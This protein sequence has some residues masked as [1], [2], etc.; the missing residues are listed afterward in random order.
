MHKLAFTCLLLLLLLPLAAQTIS[1]GDIR[2][3]DP[4]LSADGRQL[5]FSRPDYVRNQGTSSNLSD[6]WVRTVNENG[7]WGR[8]LN[9]GSPIN[10]FGAD[11]PVGLSADGNRLAVLREGVL[12]SIDVLERRGRIWSIH[13]SLP[14]PDALRGVTDLSFNPVTFRLVYASGGAESDLYYLQATP[15]G[16]WEGPLPMNLLNTDLAESRPTFSA[17]NR[18]L[19]YRSGGDW[20]RQ[21]DRGGRARRLT[22]TPWGAEQISTAPAGPVTAVVTEGRGLRAAALVS[23]DLPP[24]A[25]LTRGFVDR[26]LPPGERFTLLPVAADRTLRVLPDEQ[27]RYAVF[28][29]EGESL[30][31][32]APDRAG[33]SSG[34]GG[35]LASAAGAAPAAD[36]VAIEDD[37]ARRVAEIRRLDSLR[38]AT[39]SDYLGQ[40]DPELA[41]LTARVRAAN[42]YPTDTVPPQNATRAR[43]ADDISEL[44]RMKAKFR[45][46]QEEKLSGRRNRTERTDDIR[47]ST[48]ERGVTRLSV[49]RDTARTDDPRLRAGRIQSE[50]NNG[51]YN[52]RTAARGGSWERDLQ[53][54]LPNQERISDQDRARL[55]AEYERQMAELEE[56]RRRLRQARN[57]PDPQP[58]SAPAPARQ[59]EARSPTPSEYTAP[60][61]PPT[62]TYTPP[63][64][65][66]TAQLAGITF[67]PNTAYP[68]GPGYGAL[69]QLA[70]QVQN[71]G[72]VVEIRVH[73]SVNLDRRTAQLLSEE[74][75]VT[76]RN[77]LL[78]QGINAANFRV[79]G[80][81]NNLTGNGGERVELITT[82]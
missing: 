43:Y 79:V 15:R 77:Y 6:V 63:P 72:V 34:T 75:A 10:S 32:G 82:R 71:S 67:I 5:F 20:F 69:D 47:W 62:T 12:P 21:G 42:G 53:R 40:P 18:T 17:D 73:T 49:P 8:A 80:Y 1:P 81:G 13:H 30:L 66:T 74:R 26:P 27:Q 56:M 33:Y 50:V 51:L 24:A 19:Y 59:W 61:A 16:D 65:E 28:L 78:E 22:S 7:R 38:R 46:Q 9:P 76:I 2:E 31:S 68:N 36:P 39:N 29:R 70:R 57:E 52:D 14:L 60:A 55:D 58:A 4:Y 11:R 41:A 48:Q 3:R 45:R 44:E 35:S 25:R 37:I 54:D 64:T 23:D